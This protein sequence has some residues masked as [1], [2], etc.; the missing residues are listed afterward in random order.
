MSRLFLRQTVVSTLSE[1]LRFS[2]L[3]R[4]TTWNK[5]RSDHRIFSAIGVMHDKICT[6][7]HRDWKM[8]KPLRIVVHSNRQC[9]HYYTWQCLLAPPRFCCDYTIQ[10]MC[11]C[12]QLQ[13]C[14]TFQFHFAVLLIC[15][16]VFAKKKKRKKKRKKI[17]LSMF[18]WFLPVCIPSSL[19][20]YLLTHPGDKTINV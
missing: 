16:Q 5:P 2:D 10:H 11:T 1:R 17:I 15:V 20:L 19:R 7:T 3:W 4:C 13:L 14:K 18:I 9:S 6:E 8:D 12:K